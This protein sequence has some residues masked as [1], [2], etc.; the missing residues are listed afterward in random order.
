MS[1][2][3]C[4]IAGSAQLLVLALSPARTGR[5][6]P[7]PLILAGCPSGLWQYLLT[8]RRS[9]P[10]SAESPP[11]ASGALLSSLLLGGLYVPCAVVLV[12][13]RATSPGTATPIIFYRPLLA[14]RG[15]VLDHRA[16]S[17]AAWLERL[18]ERW[19]DQFGPGASLRPQRPGCIHN[20]V[21]LPLG[22]LGIS[23]Y[24][25]GNS[26]PPGGSVI[27]V[28]ASPTYSFP[29]RSTRLAPLRGQCIRFVRDC[30]QSPRRTCVARGLCPPSH[31]RG[32]P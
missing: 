5:L 19:R 25:P 6:H 27:A 3:P 28:L 29:S 26:V 21:F 15:Y 13:R 23:P 12:I 16:L 8:F 32:P 20:L 22:A 7:L 14:L 2:R 18:P 4:R 31:V 24:P 10:A 1:W 30:L 11:L 9:A 17:Y